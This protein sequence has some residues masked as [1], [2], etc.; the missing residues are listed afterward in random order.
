MKVLRNCFPIC[1]L[2]LDRDHQG[3]RDVRAPHAYL[4]SSLCVVIPIWSQLPSSFFVA[5]NSVSV[6]RSRLQRYFEADK[7]SFGL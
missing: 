5:V 1:H 2:V 3:I 7:F 6:F 4:S